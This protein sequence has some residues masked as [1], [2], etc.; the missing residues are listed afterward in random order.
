[1][2]VVALLGL[3]LWGAPAPGLPQ[4]TPPEK[5]LE[6]LVAPAE[7]VPPGSASSETAPPLPP[8][9]AKPSGVPPVAPSPTNAASVPVVDAPRFG[10]PGQVVLTTALGA[11]LGHVGVD[12]GDSLV[13]GVLIEPALHYIQSPNDSVGIEVF[14]NYRETTDAAQIGQESLSYG[15]VGELGVNRWLGQ[16]VSIWA[17]LGAGLS[18]TRATL[19]TTS[20]IAQ[21]VDV[22]ENAVVFRLFA[23]LLLHVA[24]NLFVGLGPDVYLDV[25]HSGAGIPSRSFVGASSS[26]GGWK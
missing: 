26:V 7:P 3:W 6:P 22:T 10:R 23:P 20:G 17:R 9:V 21:T 13:T 14:L 15:V 4:E 18:Q 24:P 2:T 1:M 8:I 5:I 12:A 16:R 19:S 25:L 11:S